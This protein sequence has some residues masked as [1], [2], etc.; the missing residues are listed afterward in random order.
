MAFQRRR[1]GFRGGLR[2][3][4]SPE[5]LAEERERR[6][7]GGA[8][9]TRARELAGRVHDAVLAEEGAAVAGKEAAR[10]GS[11]R[12]ASS[13]TSLPRSV[14]PIVQWCSARR[15]RY[16]GS[17][18]L[19]LHELLEGGDGAVVSGRAVGLR[20]RPERTDSSGFAATTA[21]SSRAASRARPDTVRATA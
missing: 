8:G 17:S 6:E 1:E 4:R 15:M 19:S 2:I 20:Q 21:S 11:A 10:P 7:V 9:V 13:R 5:R 12:S 16:C 3:A 18:G 14:L